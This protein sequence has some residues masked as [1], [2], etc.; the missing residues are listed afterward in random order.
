MPELIPSEERAN[1]MI[2]YFSKLLKDP[3]YY[4]SKKAAAFTV[5]A[6]IDSQETASE[7]FTNYWGEVLKHVYAWEKEKTD[8]TIT[9]I[10]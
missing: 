5:T 1:Q 10:V 8:N 9:V 3:S 7:Y 6:I 4:Y 2:L